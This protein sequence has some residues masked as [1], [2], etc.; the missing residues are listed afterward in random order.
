MNFPN[1]CY[2]PELLKTM[3]DALDAAKASSN[4]HYGDPPAERCAQLWLSKS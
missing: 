4:Q 1:A 3:T 2:D